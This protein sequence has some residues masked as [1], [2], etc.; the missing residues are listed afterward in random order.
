MQKNDSIEMTYAA[1]PSVWGGG[2][3]VVAASVTGLFFHFGSVLVI[4]FSLFL[5]PLSEEFGWTRTQVSLAFTLACLTALGSML[6]V[7]RLTDRFGA[8]RVILISMAFFGALFALLSLLTPQLWFLYAVFAALGIFGP[9]TSAVP[10]ASL[11]SRWF[12]ARR[13]LAL[14]VM[15]CGTGTGG[16]LWPVIG[17]SL[18]DRAGW[19]A[20]YLILGAA[21]L[22]V[23]GPVLLLFLK[24]PAHS[25]TAS[26]ENRTAGLSRREALGS[27]IFWLLMGSFFVASAVVQACQ[28]HLSPLLTDR[29]LSAQRAALAISVF[30]GANLVGRLGTGWLLDRLSSVL[31]ALLAFGA[32][33]LGI[34][35]L[36]A[37]ASIAGACAAGALVGFGYG[38]ET[39][40]A[41]YL[42]SRYFGLRAFG[43]VY[44]YLFISVPLGGAVGPALMG[45]GF[46]RT[47]SYQSAL[48]FG[49]GFMAVAALS[50]LNL[51]RART[52][53]D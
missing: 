6:V 25:P 47:G 40:A 44:S 49:L 53:A 26:T 15:M 8:R 52:F 38:A 5:K 35:L 13:G 20:A 4:T 32:I 42:V 28:V 41:P 2:W 24:E 43:E 46:D 51:R 45:L 3:P 30:G 14:G 34:A 33:M 31:V 16:I 36:L 7:G 19:R 10:H 29:G 1:G 12:T 21:V 50:I 11:I 17:Q 48:L 9:G 39:S 27:W 37:G 18:I 23:A 22:L